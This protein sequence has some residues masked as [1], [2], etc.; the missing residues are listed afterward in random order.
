M[1]D[2]LGVPPPPNL[3][4]MI[5]ND[6]AACFRAQGARKRELEGENGTGRDD[7]AAD[8]RRDTT[9]PAILVDFV[10]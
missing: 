2:D 1:V 7:R 4:E 6:E 8:Q 5:L 10:S 9:R 3:E